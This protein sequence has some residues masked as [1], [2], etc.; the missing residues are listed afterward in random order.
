MFQYDP[1]QTP[2]YNLRLLLQEQNG[3]G[4]YLGRFNG[5]E[6]IGVLS[7]KSLFN[8]EG[9][10]LTAP[11]GT[12]LDGQI[13]VWN[14]G[15][16]RLVWE[17]NEARTLFATVR[18]ETGSIVPKG[19]VVYISGAA[20]NKAL[21][22]LAI[23]TSDITSATT[24]AVTAEDIADNQNGK[25]V[26]SGELTGIDTSAFT[27]GAA[28]YLSP[29]VAGGFTTTKPS[30]PE[31]LVYVATVV[32]SHATQGV[33]EVRIQNG[34]ELEEI[35][36]V[37]VM[38]RANNDVLVYESATELWKGKT[39]AEILGYTPA[40]LS[41]SAI[42][43][44]SSAGDT[45]VSLVASQP[46]TVVTITA[47]A[48]IAK[49]THNIVLQA[50]SAEVGAFTTVHIDLAAS[51]NPRI[52]LRNLT[53]AGT[54][55]GEAVANNE[56]RRVT[57]RCVFDGT[58]WSIVSRMPASEVFFFERNIDPPAGA[59][60]S[61]TGPFTWALP[62]GAKVIDPWVVSGGG[63]GA[64]GRRGAAG[65]ARFGG[66]GGASGNTSQ[67]TTNVSSLAST[68]LVITVGAGG[69]GGPAVTV[70]NT[71]GN[72]GTSGGASNIT[73][74]G[75]MLVNAIVGGGG[76]VGGTATAGTG[77]TANSN[78]AR[79][80]IGCNGGA[81]SVTGTGASGG[82][83]PGIN[84]GGGGAG[85]GISNLDVAYGG[86]TG[87]YPMFASN[88][89]TGGNNTGGAGN[90]ASSAL[91]GDTSFVGVGAGGGGASLLTAGGDGGTGQRGSGGGGG[92][93]SVNGS[94]SGKG[95]DG[96]NGA[97]RITVFY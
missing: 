65:S 6:P 22:S 34:Y 51:N 15:A 37:A 9:S 5:S 59:T 26:V 81:S 50:G 56:A 19:S 74:G 92:G 84:P 47:S 4:T 67:N 45:N 57:F 23:A 12:P 60:G 44:V 18:N 77:G 76:G 21:V 87:S 75:R 49:Y 29:S 73:C 69:T 30:A 39:I 20:G 48:G 10:K 89:A 53:N 3:V 8:L 43:S 40:R 2:E 31:H 54:I 86:G 25:C 97:A 72:N 41:G 42:A 11:E 61:A 36:D 28:L 71:N 52:V 63:G 96:G 16:S 78:S 24:F 58:N 82:F 95:G 70:D 88:G 90:N 46:S 83:A 35:H 66:G 80:W 85:G 68:T 27:E 17:D 64:S 91:T 93:A 13:V 7:S 79:T 55:I 62:A 38:D 94:N 33:I 14:E 32:R 1:K